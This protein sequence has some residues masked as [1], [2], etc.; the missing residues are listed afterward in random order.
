MHFQHLLPMRA[1]Y[2]RCGP[3]EP[4]ASEVG[5]RM[6]GGGDALWTSGDVNPPLRF[7]K[8]DESNAA[9]R[10]LQ[11]FQSRD[12]YGLSVLRYLENAGRSDQAVLPGM[13]SRVLQTIGAFQSLYRDVRLA[14]QG[15]KVIWEDEEDPDA[16][17]DES[18]D[19]FSDDGDEDF[20]A[21]WSPILL[22]Y[23]AS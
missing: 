22:T 8:D 15:S 7:I 23:E 21:H 19:E 12:G 1:D 10:L 6:F 17:V 3:E 4:R 20:E 5:R 9:R 13:R 14:Q 16:V 2:L 11:F 18:D